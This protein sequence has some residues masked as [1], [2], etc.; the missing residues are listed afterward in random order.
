MEVAVY[1]ALILLLIIILWEY[2]RGKAFAEGFTDGVVPEFF[3]RYFPRRYDIVPGQQ[4]EM[5]GWIRNP[6]YFEG[7]VDVQRLGYKGDFCRV[8]EK[9]SMPESRIMACALAGQE[10]LDPYIYRTESV[11]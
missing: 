9:E 11:S 1:T 7:Y 5:D 3:G 8:V 2:L 10:G 4:K 6:R